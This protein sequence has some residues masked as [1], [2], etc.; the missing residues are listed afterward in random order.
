MIDIKLKN[1]H[2]VSIVCMF[3]TITAPSQKDHTLIILPKL[4]LCHQ[5]C[6]H[7]TTFSFNLAYLNFYFFPK[8]QVQKLTTRECN[9]VH[10][11]SS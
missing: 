8:M 6:C 5:V 2:H 10:Q 1:V 3:N 9:L 11:N 4:G 7:P